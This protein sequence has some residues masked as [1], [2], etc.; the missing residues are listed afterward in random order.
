MASMP[1]WCGC[2][3]WALTWTLMCVF[4]RFLHNLGP[5]DR[6]SQVAFSA[7]RS[8]LPP[9]AGMYTRYGSVWGGV[10]RNLWCCVL[11][12]RRSS[13]HNHYLLGVLSKF[14]NAELG[15]STFWYR[16]GKISYGVHVFSPICCQLPHDLDLESIEAFM[17]KTSKPKTPKKR[18][19][20]GGCP[21]QIRVDT[22][23]SVKPLPDVV[24]LRAGYCTFEISTSK[25][26][27][28]R[29]F[30]FAEVI[31]CGSETGEAGTCPCRQFGLYL[32]PFVRNQ[33]QHGQGGFE[34]LEE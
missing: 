6:Q 19:S 13:V 30:A 22:P 16:T 3:S 15:F 12:A 29:V 10:A 26:K 20:G 5:A 7:L 23:L 1:P 21:P 27:V 2:C 14:D 33:R 32:A 17:P 4:A 34:T 18:I 25:C 31:I 28:L 11:V 9:S 8:G 24:L